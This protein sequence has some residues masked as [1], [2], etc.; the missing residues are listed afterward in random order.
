VGHGPARALT[1]DGHTRER[2]AMAESSGRRGARQGEP[3]SREEGARACHG[4][5]TGSCAR[6]ASVRARCTGT[7]RESLG[8]ETGQRRSTETRAGRGQGLDRGSCT[9]V[10]GSRAGV[11][12][13]IEPGPDAGMKRQRG[14]GRKKRLERATVG[15]LR[16]PKVL[17]NMI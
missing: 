11:D 12:G 4:D 5:S 8:T 2:D 7:S 10:P 17:K 6:R 9:R 16:L 1:G 13:L 15:G 3:A 14:G